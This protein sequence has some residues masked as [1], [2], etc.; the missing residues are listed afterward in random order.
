MAALDIK[1][2]RRGHTC[3]M[4]IEMGP[5]W[6]INHACK[7]I[8]ANKAKI[9]LTTLKTADGPVFKYQSYEINR[10]TSAINFNPDYPDRW[11]PVR[12]HEHRN[13]KDFKRCIKRK[14]STN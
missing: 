9:V 12:I 7:V 13:E 8:V 10:E 14:Q 11:Y 4:I 6:T 3:R 5:G 2:L 1:K